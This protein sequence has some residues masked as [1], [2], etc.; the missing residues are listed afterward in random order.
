MG[1]KLNA[2]RVPQKAQPFQI[3]LE[4]LCAQNAYLNTR[5]AA[6]GKRLSLLRIV[7]PCT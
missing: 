3:T 1:K 7:G 5:K 6:F 2:M 4:S